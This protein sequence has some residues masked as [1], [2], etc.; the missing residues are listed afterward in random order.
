MRLSKIIEGLKCVEISNYIDHNI[1]CLS[2]Q[3]NECIENTIFFAI[4]GGKFDGK[5]YVMDAIK[6]GA[7]VIVSSVKIDTKMTNIVVDNVRQSMSIMAKNFYNKSDEK[8]QKIAIVGTNGKTTSSFVLGN[9][10]KHY[11]KKVGIIGTNGVYID[12]EYNKIKEQYERIFENTIEF[13]N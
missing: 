9:I 3:S 8:L 13:I 2:F 6:Y 12:N 11:G 7:K 10:L 4:E 5:D 1:E